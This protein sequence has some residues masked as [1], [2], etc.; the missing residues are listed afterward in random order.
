VEETDSSHKLYTV[1][2]LWLILIV[3]SAT[4]IIVVPKRVNSTNQQSSIIAKDISSTQPLSYSIVPPGEPSIITPIKAE[5]P[6]IQTVAVQVLPPV[7]VNP[8]KPTPPPQDPQA[9]KLVRYLKSQGSPIATYNLAELLI[10]TSNAS[11]IDYKLIVAIA[12]T[13]SGFCRVNYMGYNCF[14]YLNSVHYS[15]FDSAIRN[16]IPLISQN[17]IRKFGTN[18][19]A[20]AAAYGYQDV[21]AGAKNLATYYYSQN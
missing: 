2:K 18:F 20:F 12:G 13:E 14:G 15:S 10:N 11:G 5:A 7:I 16:L 17:Y 9:L 19:K 21:A 4:Y 6:V 3:L 8:P 1:L